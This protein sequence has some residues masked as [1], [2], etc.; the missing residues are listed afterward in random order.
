MLRRIAKVFGII[1]LSVVLLA[2]V[3]VGWFYHTLNQ[4]LVP[5]EN[6]AGFPSIATYAPDEEAA[7]PDLEQKALV[8]PVDW[9]QLAS[10]PASARPW[11]RWWWPGGDVRADVATAQ[12]DSLFQA[13]FG[14]VEI[15]PFISGMIN[16]ADNEALMSR[17]YSFDSADYYT[18]LNA[19]VEHAAGLGMQVD[20]THFSGWPPG[21]PE[22]LLEDSVT[23]LVTASERVEGGGEI[24]RKLP[25]P[26]PGP[27]ERIFSA[28]ELAGAD[29]INYP[30]DHAR[31]LS[32]TAARVE[33][34]EHA[35]SPFNVN[36]TVFIDGES[37]QV[38]T[39]KVSIEKGL[40]ATLRWNAPEG[41]WQ[42]IAHY[43]MPSGEVPMGAAQKPQGFVVDHL[44]SAQVLGHYEY[45]YGE[46][47]GL[48]AQY[49]KGLR[50]FFNDSLEFRVT[51]MA[52]E[53][54]LPEF[55]A[56]R[57]YDLEPYLPVIH[58]EGF[59]NVYFRELLGVHSAPEYAISPLDERI[60]M[61]YQQTLSDLIVERFVEGSAEWAAQRGLV[62]RGQSYG[63]DIDLLRAMGAN[64]IPE[65]EQLWAG[66]ANV[67]LKFA[68]SAAAL[69]GRP[70]VSAE[71]FVWINRDYQPTARR[72][73]AAADKLMLAGINHIIY[74][75]T[76]YPWQGSGNGEY[77]E[78]G[79]QPFSGPGNPAHFSGLYSEANTSLWPDL[80]E[81]NQTITRSQHLLRQGAPVLDVLVYYPFLGFHGPN[82]D[83]EGKEVLV[84]GSL[85]D[86]D[87]ASV[88][89]EAPEL[90]AGKEQLGK[91][92]TVPPKQTDH[93]VTWMEALQPT[94]DELDRRGITWG[95]VNDHALQSGLVENGEL[96]AS[97]GRYG[98]ILLADV[99]SLPLQ[100]V[101][102]LARQ[103]A[104]GVPVY[105]AGQLP[106]QQRSFLNAERGDAAVVQGVA[107]LVQGHFETGSAALLEALVQASPESARY[108][109]PS[110]IHRQR[111]VLQDGSEIT[112]F[113]NQSASGADVALRDVDANAWWFDP[114]TGATW[115]A[116]IQG[117]ELP[118]EL[119]AWE[120]RF[121]I[122]GVEIPASSGPQPPV[123]SLARPAQHTHALDQWSLELGD[124]QAAPAPL[125]DWREIDAQ[126]YAA[127]PGIYRHTLNLDPLNA[128]SRY[129][130][131]LGLVQGSATVSVNGQTLG[132]ASVPPSRV[133]ITDALQP[134]ENHIEVSLRPPLRNSFVGRGLSGDPLY[135][136]MQGY[137]DQ[138]VAA[139]LIGPV[140][141]S[142]F[143]APAN[144]DSDAAVRFHE[145]PVDA[146]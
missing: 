10:P 128:G 102:A 58:V 134:G 135:S 4:A 112:F 130:L 115:S 12:L 124:Y 48:P 18:T 8:E 46:R 38:L 68:S 57:G 34:G 88:M 139:G 66:G 52:V 1:L 35:W 61:D 80:P 41:S 132:Q 63:M 3:A 93:R 122:S 120:S 86:A 103:Q 127:G 97:G 144:R 91:L 81:L 28:I 142:E 94:L 104:Q 50:G 15:Q 65:T 117:D 133:D 70:L 67:G 30:A 76:P 27:S 96:T 110:T 54:I 53:D 118:V 92:M 145:E 146:R 7:T 99:P 72:L 29:F 83:R 64:T 79:W 26:E 73:K 121:L 5:P 33:A 47:T 32:V 19:T 37:L 101:D 119:A 71:S 60:R 143:A 40:D 140:V 82:A 77:G 131:D 129:V 138:L 114:R 14:G 113:A 105:F 16:V 6:P 62:S 106:S 44:R 126:R 100:T 51:R 107:N 84:S 55:R 74:H 31:L 49:G 22:V 90:T 59:D 24:S 123:T 69:Y 137:Q 20:L 56:R 108:A 87:P 43:L 9:Q 89:L 39:D 125:R 136:H 25:R 36:D 23:T 45:A 42:I 75:G 21:G 111:R 109:R 85:P 141:L 116:A 2:A 95:W 98:A 17:V 11:T 13:G 78:E